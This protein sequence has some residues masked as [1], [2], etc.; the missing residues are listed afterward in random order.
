[1]P[2]DREPY[3]LMMGYRGALAKTLNHLN[4]RYSV[5]NDKPLK[6]P[7]AGVDEVYVQ[8]YPKNQAEL[9]NS[10]TEIEFPLPPTHVLASIEKTVFPS[11][12]VR[13]QFNAR[14]SA[15]SILIRCTDKVQMKRYLY[16]KGI[17]MTM[18]S[19]HSRE[20]SASDL[21]ANLGAPVVIKDRIGSGSRNI[22][23]S[24][25]PET[26]SQAMGPGRVYESFVDGDEGSIESFVHNSEIVFVNVTEYYS[27]T[28]ANIL[29]APFAESELNALRD[30]NNRVIK[31]LKIKWGMTHLEYYRTKDGLL[32]GEIA[33]RPP[34][35]HIMDLIG[36][37]YDIDPWEYFVR[38]ELDLPLF[39]IESKAKL[40][41]GCLILHP[42][43]GIVKSVTVPEKKDFPTLLKAK[44]KV[45]EGSAIDKRESVGKD[46]GYCIF[47]DEKP[48]NVREDIGKLMKNYPITLEAAKG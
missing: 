41:A 1:M 27:K 45:T 19:D 30:L 34:G 25:D 22:V 33:L 42:G 18:Y 26:I 20:L 17:P 7:P 29:P 43:D 24:S 3:V 16:G 2:F 48:E 35:G 4:I 40:T 12:L 21:L 10:L 28:K 5:W 46:S 31:E 11:A 38:I 15:K 13:R 36:E 39:S 8:A 44:I 32:F 23:I 9:L 37:A 6:T 14:S 47:S